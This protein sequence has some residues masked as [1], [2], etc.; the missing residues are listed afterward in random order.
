M[1]AQAGDGKPGQ[2]DAAARSGYDVSLGGYMSREWS[3]QFREEG[4]DVTWGMTERERVYSTLFFVPWQVERF[5]DFGYLLCLDSVLAVLTLLPLRA[6]VKFGRVGLGIGKM[7]PAGGYA[8][9]GT[10]RREN[11]IDSRRSDEPATESSDAAHPP[12]VL[13]RG[14]DINDVAWLVLVACGALMLCKLDTGAIYHWIRSQEVIKLYVVYN[15]LEIL[16]RMLCSFGSDTLEALASSCGLLSREAAGGRATHAA[17]FSLASDLMVSI[18][19]QLMHAVVLMCQA[20]TF[21]VAVNSTNNNLLGLLVSNNFVE[22]KGNIFKR[23]DFTRVHILSLQ[24]VVERFHISSALCFVLVES[25]IHMSSPIPAYH[26]VRQCAIVL[27]AEV[28]VDVT[29]H[30]FLG[31]YNALRPGI[32]SEFQRDLSVKALQYHSGN[33]HRALG[34][35]P[36]AAAALVVRIA[37]AVYVHLTESVLEPGPAAWLQLAGWAGGG[38]L[39]MLGGKVVLGFVVRRLAH[40]YVQYHKERNPTVKRL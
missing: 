22:I 32:Y 36:P 12:E 31:K 20:I 40:S 19:V 30:A 14:E 10:R 6:A 29:K 23:M 33:V 34:F 37:Y 3:A 2:E 26:T 16:D 39:A 35:H 17:V 21:S 24:D 13:I 1:R 25:M 27:V 18:F 9:V 5:V 11:S 4:P 28:L 38:Y 7:Q 8:A 15:S